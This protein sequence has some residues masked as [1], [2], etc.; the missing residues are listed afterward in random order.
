MT[1]LNISP[2][3]FGVANT[4]N[5][6]KATGTNTT[7]KSSGTFSPF[8][9]GNTSTSSGWAPSGWA[10]SGINSGNWSDAIKRIL[11]YLFAVCIVVIIL[12]L[13]VHFFIRPVFKWKPG[14]PGIIPVPGW[15]DGILFWKDGH[16]GLVKNDELPISNQSFDYTVQLDMLIQN[17]LQFASYPRLLLSRGAIKKST[18]S[19]DTILSILDQYNFAVALKPDTNDMIVSVLNKDKQME[20]V[21]LPNVPV[22]EPFRLTMVVMEKA[23]EVYLNGHLVKTT[24][25]HAPPMDVKGSIYAATGVEA[26]IARYRNLKI[27][28]RILTTPEIRDSTPRLST[29]E[30]MGA[31]PI[32]ASSSCPMPSSSE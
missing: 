29:A 31:G 8:T 4:S 20:S 25:F 6:S 17:P 14:S 26:N 2:Y 15:D 1:S 19:G 23:L 21:I 24:M 13:F 12:L 22:Q 28:S 18:P 30:E 27:W 16:T 11:T 7:N 5:R 10:P 3:L 9:F 32:P